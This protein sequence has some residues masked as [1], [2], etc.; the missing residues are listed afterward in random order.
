M[1]SPV[2]TLLL[3][4]AALA[5]CIGAAFA[6]IED[7]QTPDVTGSGNER[8]E[9]RLA[10]RFLAEFDMNH[11][12]KV[13]HDEFNRTLA[14]HFA[15]IA[16]KSPT[17]TEEQFINARMKEL[18]A[19]SDAMFRRLD[20]NGD[21]RVSLEE[22]LQPVRARFELADRDGAG[23]IDCAVKQ[24]ASYEPGAPK[25]RFG[26]FRGRGSL[27]AKNDLNQDGKLTR[28]ELDKA[29]AQEFKGPSLTADQFYAITVARY[30]EVASKM[31]EHADADRDG[32]LTLAEFA[33]REEK[34]FARLDKN[35]DNA[36]TRDEM[37]SS[38]RPRGDRA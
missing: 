16:G 36:V 27:C 6:Q 4:S 33:A 10:D 31:F 20:W 15:W 14:A 21:G 30:R 35:H 38:R 19:H 8:P 18:R 5:V 9:G 7:P 17:I 37:S 25:R 34:Y 3:A 11:D 12:G 26:G 32:K 1:K 22:F 23:Q 29:V 28:A 2:R 13:T 24:K